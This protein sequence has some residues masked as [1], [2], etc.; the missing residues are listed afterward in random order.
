MPALPKKRAWP[1]VLVRWFRSLNWR[2]D[3]E[4]LTDQ[5]SSRDPHFHLLVSIL[6][7]SLFPNSTTHAELPRGPKIRES[8]HLNEVVCCS[9]LRRSIHHIEGGS[10]H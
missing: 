9:A 2:A 3:T 7:D 5:N 1:W 8:Y 6:I 10:S 4:W